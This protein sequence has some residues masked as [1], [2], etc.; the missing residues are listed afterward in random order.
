MA[1]VKIHIVYN[2]TDI[3]F[4]GANQFL[5][6]LRDYFIE[7]DCYSK[8]IKEADV[9]I[10]NGHLFGQGI[11]LFKIIWTHRHLLKEKTVLHRVDGP[12]SLYQENNLFPVDK[13]IFKIS[14]F[15]SDGTV[16]QSYWSQQECKRIGMPSKPFELVTINAPDPKVFFPKNLLPP[17]GDEKFK[18]IANSWSTNFN[19]GFDVLEYLETH[20]DF[21]KYEMTFIGRSPVSFRNI[22]LIN[23]LPSLQLA[24]IL[25]EH[26]LFVTASFRE[27]CSNSLLEAMHCGC[28]PIARNTSSHP[29]IVADAGVLFDGQDDVLKAIDQAAENY[30]EFKAKSHLPSIT[31]IGQRYYEFCLK[32]HEEQNPKERDFSFWRALSFLWDE[33]QIRIEK[34]LG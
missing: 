18:L 12:V 11:T 24:E 29:D 17:S 9:I 20:L 23:S 1:T 34:R 26:H 4:G 25:R 3:P 5:K 22:K 32:V 19:K 10:L 31:E 27:A 30:E 7:K 33:F 8:S 2:F 28:I 21:N 16:F 15:V 13:Y 6:A 14:R